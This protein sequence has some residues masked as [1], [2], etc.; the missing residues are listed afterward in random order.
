[1]EEQL[2]GFMDLPIKQE[3]DVQNF[4]EKVPIFHEKE[5]N[6]SPKESLS[7]SIPSILEGTIDQPADTDF[8]AFKLEDGADLA[9]EIETP[10]SP[11]P[12][13]NPRVTVI[14]EYGKEVVDNI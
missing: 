7:F 4:D 2:K 10:D 12:F 14:D 5:P 1:M 11:Y 9:L 6:D 8:F 3:E 13:F